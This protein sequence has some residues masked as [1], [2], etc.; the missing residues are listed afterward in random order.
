[1]ACWGGDGE[2]TGR[3]MK[4][5]L[6]RGACHL[7]VDDPRRFG[8]SVERVLVSSW[9]LASALTGFVEGTAVV[10]WCIVLNVGVSR[11]TAE[12]VFCCLLRP[13]SGGRAMVVGIIHNRTGVFCIFA[14]RVSVVFRRLYVCIVGGGLRCDA[15]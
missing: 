14:A 9:G 4:R 12:G 10:C 13:L 1:M 11:H 2:R 3:L 7:R 6:G 15:T 5:R 8:R